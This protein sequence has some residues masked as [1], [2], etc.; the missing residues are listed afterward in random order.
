[1][2]RGERVSP[3]EPPRRRGHVHGRG[4]GPEPSAHR[5]QLRQAADQLRGTPHRP[6]RR[7]GQALPRGLGQEE[8]RV[9]EPL[10][11]P[12]REQGRPPSRPAPCPASTR[13]TRPTT[14][15]PR[16]PF[17]RTLRSGGSPRTT[18]SY[19]GPDLISTS[20]SGCAS[21]Y[22]ISCCFSP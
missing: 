8:A 19:T 3:L 17:V 15:A 11:V 10:T 2:L 16:C 21:R 22:S 20:V 7:P 4:V 18:S 13:P 1:G 5:H 9:E 6:R 12:P 14:T